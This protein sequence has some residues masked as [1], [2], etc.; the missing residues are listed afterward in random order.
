MSELVR[1]KFTAQ[2]RRQAIL[3]VVL[4]IVLIDWIL[5]IRIRFSVEYYVPIRVLIV[6]M[7][8][9]SVRKALISFIKTIKR[10]KS[11]F[12]MYFSCCLFA[13][14]TGNVMFRTTLN[15]DRV[16][17]SYSNIIRS[18][19][20]SLVFF[21]TGANYV[22]LV[23]PAYN[24]ASIYV[25]YFS[26]IFIMG[27]FVVLAFVLSSFVRSFQREFQL[28]VLKKKQRERSGIFAAF[29]L[30]DFDFS[31]KISP[32]MLGLFFEAIT[33]DA[34]DSLETKEKRKQDFVHKIKDLGTFVDAVEDL[35]EEDNRRKY[36]IRL[37][38]FDELVLSKAFNKAPFQR[39]VPSADSSIKTVNR[40]DS[41]ERT[42]GFFSSSMLSLGSSSEN[43]TR[44]RKVFEIVSNKFSSAM[45]TFLVLAQC[46]VLTF[47]GLAGVSD[48]FVDTVNFVFV[49][50]FFIELCVK[51]YC[52]GLDAFLNP[53]RY[54]FPGFSHLNRPEYEVANRLDCIA[55][56]LAFISNVAAMIITNNFFY[57]SH[58]FAK[59]R[60][61][62]VFL[63]VRIFTQVPTTRRLIYPVFIGTVLKQ[64][65][66]LLFLLGLVLYIFGIYG[67]LFFHKQFD[68][69][70]LQGSLPPGNF[71]DLSQ[72]FLELL[73]ML[74]NFDHTVMYAAIL[75][76]DFQYAWYF[77]SYVIIVTL[78]FT[79]IFI[80]LILTIM[81][82]FDGKVEFTKRGFEKTL[83]NS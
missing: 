80:S 28:E 21:S 49:F 67:V 61:G 1:V 72:S 24:L 20:T 53:T 33:F 77:I 18:I 51:I 76:K 34:R 81:E 71:N 62:M 43:L 7:M 8:N 42:K 45:I 37:G 11:A 58:T 22:D 74:V 78:L 59:L 36:M 25:L 26:L 66:N 75:M 69:A 50:L 57:A 13:A 82:K 38:H 44:R 64:F 4:S 17:S 83:L 65:L 9:D 48:E 6:V 54:K 70:V 79:N 16:N 14:I 32:K 23:F 3:L 63:L 39:P 73:Y 19:T 30:L 68:P 2:L 56:L 60:F 12:I 31:G 27:N 46:G 29:A 55:I 5:S 52:Y 15:V 10:A 40:G 47:Y 35:I 41:L